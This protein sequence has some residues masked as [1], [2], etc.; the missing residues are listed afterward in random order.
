MIALKLF[1]R[2]NLYRLLNVVVLT[3]LF[4]LAY[5]WKPLYY[6]NQNDYF[7]HGMAKAGYGFLSYDWILNKREFMPL[8]TFI[9]Y[10]TTKYLAQIWFYVYWFLLGGIYIH[11]LLGIGC[12]FSRISYGSKLYY[13]LFSMLTFFHSR[14]F[15]ELFEKGQS[16]FPWLKGHFNEGALFLHWGVANQYVMNTYFQPSLFGVFIF[17]GLWLWLKKQWGWSLVCDCVAV[18]FHPGLMFVILMVVLLKLFFLPSIEKRWF[19]FNSLFSFISLGVYCAVGPTILGGRVLF[20]VILGFQIGMI[21]LNIWCY[22]RSIASLLSKRVRGV[23][24]LGLVNFVLMAMVF[25]R[26]MVSELRAPDRPISDHV[27]DVMYAFHTNPMVWFNGSVVLQLMLIVIAAVL[28]RKRGFHLFVWL[29]LAIIVGGVLLALWM[30]SLGI[31]FFN[32]LMPWRLSVVIVPFALV[33]IMSWVIDRLTYVSKALTFSVIGIAGV[34]VAVF[35][36]MDYTKS[37]FYQQK[38]SGLY[39]MMDWIKAEN[40]EGQVY[41]TPLTIIDFRLMTGVPIFVGL[42]VPPNKFFDTRDAFFEWESRRDLVASFYS[43]SGISLRTLRELCVNYSV[44]HVLIESNHPLVVVLKDY[45]LHQ[46]VGWVVIHLEAVRQGLF[47]S[48]GDMF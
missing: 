1:N 27:V 19:L 29:G 6:S 33:V 14:L 42:K 45:R 28:L 15:Y 2:I 36:G 8:V 22:R 47:S 32:A 12:F 18:S 39:R 21:L 38:Q 43:Q 26:L 37:E 30:S 46:T 10:L 11:S 25:I 31:L 16:F 24:L 7:L 4:C 17:L 41:V 34:L 13:M 35:F 44:S 5:S 23:V 9:V 20:V 40:Q 48:Q 3:V